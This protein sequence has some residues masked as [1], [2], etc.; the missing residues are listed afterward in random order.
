MPRGSNTP[1]HLIIGDIAD[2]YATG[3]GRYAKRGN[4]KY[5]EVLDYMDSLKSYGIVP[6]LDSVR[7]LC[8]RLGNPQE[9]LGASLQ[10][11]AKQCVT[12]AVVKGC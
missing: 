2:K 3:A 10:G 7:E 1:Q 12:K 6:G 8:R 4:M 11:V 9:G 5:Q